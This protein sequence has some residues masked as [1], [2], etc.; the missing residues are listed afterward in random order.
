[1]PKYRKI[2]VKATES[3]DINEMPDD[4]TRL[5]W[6]MLPLGLDREGR[7]M[8]NPAWVKAKVM[9]LR[10]DVGLTR[11]ETALDWYEARGMIK[12][13]EVDKRRYFWVPSFIK[14]QGNTTK[15]TESNFPSPPDQLQSNSRVTPELQQNNSCT[16][17]DAVADSNADAVAGQRKPIAA[18]FLS[19]IQ[20][21]DLLTNI[22]GWSRIP[23]NPADSANAL[24][25]VVDIVRARGSPDGE[26][27]IRSCFAEFRERYPRSTK[28][29]WLTDWAVQGVIPPKGQPPNGHPKTGISDDEL[30]AAGY[31]LR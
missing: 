1:M 24:G 7:G 6:I 26:E 27:W 31:D 13:Y 23:G 3:F 14:Y 28:I 17:A 20:A 10:E 22:T 9:P 29:F 15:E 11:I 12:R 30:R 2:H 18:A 25:A 19:S 16:D 5:L 8:D 21:Q 4:F